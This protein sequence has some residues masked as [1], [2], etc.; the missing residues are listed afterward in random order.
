MK[1]NNPFKFGSVVD[2]SYFTDRKN[3]LNEIKQALDSKNL[4]TVMLYRRKQRDEVSPQHTYTIFLNALKKG[5][6]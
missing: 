5:F 3:E 1:T 2:D 6:T 4:Q